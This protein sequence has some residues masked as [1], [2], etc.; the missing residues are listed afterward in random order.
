MAKKL[1]IVLDTNIIVSAIFFKGKPREIYDFVLN[2]RYVTI[3][4]STLISELTGILIK[5][6][7]LS[8]AEIH[9]IEH[10]IR[11]IFEVV[12]PKESIN[13][14]RDIDDNRVLEAAVEGKCQYIITGDKDLLVLKS[15]QNIEIV[16]PEQFLNR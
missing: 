3:T 9:L 1:R 11:E 12:H 4:S 5:R 10:Q 15:F 7:S 6:F 13:V 8:L 2:E 16:T 14:V